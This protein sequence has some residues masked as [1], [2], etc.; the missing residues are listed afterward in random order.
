MVALA[1]G[2]L[3][4]AVDG[5]VVATEGAHR[6]GPVLALVTWV[7]HLVEQTIQRY[8]TNCPRFSLL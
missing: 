4:P 2:V 6:C 3:H 5:D 1:A 7:L 8:E